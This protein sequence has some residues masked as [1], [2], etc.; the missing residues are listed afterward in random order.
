MNLSLLPRPQSWLTSSPT[1]STS[2]LIKKNRIVGRLEENR[3][4]CVL[5]FATTMAVTVHSQGKKG[6]TGEAQS[7]VV[8]SGTIAR[9]MPLIFFLIGRRS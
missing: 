5:I 4:C 8:H 3:E 6:R 1:G 7:P 9:F 2:M